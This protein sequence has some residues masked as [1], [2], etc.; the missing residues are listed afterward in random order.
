MRIVHLTSVHGAF[1]IRIF[2]KECKSL[3]RAGHHVT[4]IVPCERDTVVDGIHIK[5]VPIRR[6]RAARITLTVWNV[7]RTALQTEADIYH[8]HDPEL[9]VIGLLLWV[10]GHPVVYDVHED[11]PSD[12]LGKRYLP[13]LLRRPLA[14][15]ARRIEEFVC[16]HISAIVV[17]TPGIAHRLMPLN[18]NT[19]LV[20]NFSRLEEFESAYLSNWDTRDYS[21]AYV[22]GIMEERG[23]YQMVDAMELLPQHSGVRL[24]IARPTFPADIYSTVSQRP[25]WTK[26]KDWGHL[27]R[28][29]IVQL[30]SR[31]RA[32]LVLF[33]P[34]P[35]NLSAIPHKMFEYM[36]AGVPV[37]ASD[38]PN[39]RELI[40]GTGSGILVDPLQTSAIAESIAYIVSHP[41]EAH[42][43][44]LRGRRAVENLYSW[45]NEE[46]RLLD[47]Y[48]RL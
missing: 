43:M 32:G 47:L 17:V 12:I 36:A 46:K 30:L 10:L 20:R 5:A 1:D 40:L 38:F 27:D 7:F 37:I 14:H 41:T 34:V 8:F 29:G 6:Y 16:K 3:A 18:P 42:A 45:N 22:G 44:G 13:V 48:A 39:W 26:V 11:V 4:I 24:E 23:I 31:V 33:H 15:L 19:I 25:G 2:H 21:I 35:Y 28:S 9:L